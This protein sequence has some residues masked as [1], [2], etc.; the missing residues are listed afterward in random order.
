MPDGTP[1]RPSV[2]PDLLQLL[3]LMSLRSEVIDERL[4][5]SVGG[6]PEIEEVPS[7]AA[8]ALDQWVEAHVREEEQSLAAPEEPDEADP[9][10][11][12]NAPESEPAI[13]TLEADELLAGGSSPL[14][15][16]EDATI[17]RHQPAGE[18]DE[19]F[20]VAEGDQL[21]SSE[22][23]PLA[24]EGRPEDFQALLNN[25]S[26][27]ESEA[28]DQDVPLL[29]AEGDVKLQAR[30][31]AVIGAE[32]KG[33]STLAGAG[34]IYCLIQRFDLPV[35]TGVK[36]TLTGPQG[37][38]FEVADAVVK[39]VRKAPGE[40]AEVQLGFDAPNEDFEDFVANHFGAKPGRFSLFGR[41]R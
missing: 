22:S 1:P 11:V 3:K 40:S 10:R 37:K 29:P 41:W 31:G 9:E 17:A 35:G 7:A 38:A 30:T 28:D 33:K 24:G 34:G 36:L 26:L 39:R 20:Q 32:F 4:Y 15:E 25:R 14:G 16:V 8:S 13:Q 18:A 12:E 19:P 6:R 23:E 2:D 5:G 21:P 27:D